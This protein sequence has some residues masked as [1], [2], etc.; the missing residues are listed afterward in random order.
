MKI[1]KDFKFNDMG[2][3][4]EHPSHYT[5]GNIET[6]EVIKDSVPDFSSYCQGNILKY[7]IRYKHKNG[8][9]DLKKA[10]QYLNWLIIHE[11]VNGH[12]I[13]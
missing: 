1:G 2:Q 9:E 11:E 6:I 7:V 8:I 3:A 5:H 12:D 10:R 13:L 4:V